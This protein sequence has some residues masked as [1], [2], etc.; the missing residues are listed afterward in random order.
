M[1]PVDLLKVRDGHVRGDGAV[2]AK[3]QF[4][5]GCRSSILRLVV[6]TRAYRMPSLRSI[7]WRA[8][9]LYGEGSQA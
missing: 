7:D 5:R 1:Y 3:C 9:E 4:R 2:Q 6:C 8:Y